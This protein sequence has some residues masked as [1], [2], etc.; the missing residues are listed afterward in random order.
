MSKSYKTSTQKTTDQNIVRETPDQMPLQRINFILMACSG[1]L[2]VIG[3][4]LMLGPSSTQDT[5]EPDIFS[6]RRIVVG[7]TLAFLGFLSMA[8]AIIYKPRKKPEN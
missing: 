1:A 7:P 4:L 6:T 5:F 2:I 8:F 3:F